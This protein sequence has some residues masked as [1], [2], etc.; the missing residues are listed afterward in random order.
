MKQHFTLFN[1]VS[2]APNPEDSPELPRFEEDTNCLALPLE[3][4]SQ[5]VVQSLLNYS[6][7]LVVKQSDT[8]KQII[9]VLN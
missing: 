9:T 3:S 8:V 4:P 7:S 5:G 1:T 6:R 2:P